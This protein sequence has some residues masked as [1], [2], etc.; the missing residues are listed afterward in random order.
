MANEGPFIARD[1]YVA[2][3]PDMSFQYQTV[4]EL[5]TL[6]FRERCSRMGK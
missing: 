3:I 6:A 2:P 4:S 5:V 1:E